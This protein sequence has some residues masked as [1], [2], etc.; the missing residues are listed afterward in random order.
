ML[1]V[2]GST[3]LVVDDEPLLNLT[4]AILLR[5]AGASVFTA[6]NGEEALAI[7]ERERVHT[8]LCDRQM[9]VMDGLTLLRTLHA[10]GKSVPSMLFMN[11]LDREN[12]EELERMQVKRLLSKPIQPLALLAAVEDVLIRC[13][14]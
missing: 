6:T 12:T 8:M 2:A 5:R 9:P 10:R 11:G 4:F 3:L 7:L 1:G 14:A 13:H